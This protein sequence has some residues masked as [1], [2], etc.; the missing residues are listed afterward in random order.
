MINISLSK[1]LGVH[2]LL[3]DAKD[4]AKK[5]TLM[6]IIQNFIL[7]LTQTYIVLYVIDKVGFAEAAILSSILLL[8]QGILDYPLGVLS[9]SIGQKWVLSL[10]HI[11][12]SSGFIFLV[13]ANSFIEFVPIY[14]LFGLAFAL[15]S[16]AFE[17]Y[18]DNNY[19]VTV[20]DLDPDRKIYGFF[21]SRVQALTQLTSLIAFILG[22]ILSTSIGRQNSFLIQA[23]LGLL[24]SVII[25]LVLNDYFNPEDQ[26]LAK[27][28][29]KRSIANY[30]SISKA[31]IKFIFS[32]KRVFFFITG[33]ILFQSIWMIWAL[34]ILFVIYFGYTGTDLLAGVFRTT[35]F[36]LGVPTLIIV[37]NISKK[38]SDKKWIYIFHFFHSILFFGGFA[39][40]LFI[41]PLNN[42]LNLIGIILVVINF[43]L[44]GIFFDLTLVLR[45]RIMLDLIPENIRNSVYSLI[46][47]IVG[48][49]SVPFMTLVGNLI[50]TYT[51]STGILFLTLFE[52][53]AA[54]AFY[55]SFKFPEPTS[56]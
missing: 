8:F 28:I 48:L 27:N 25:Y 38:L 52:I 36:L 49:C 20:K 33:L 47:T 16:G 55:L 24:F 54:I 3:P 40:I 19:R 29:Q 45:Q 26:D 53:A 17:T 21:I 32:S 5:Y 14:A 13:F 34:L 6:I 10:S 39:L 35:V 15:F 9:D 37:G 4:L 11:C 31:G 51:I 42:T 43:S 50:V 44:T 56:N 1:F 12:F 41:I 23:I 7:L 46:P 22:G 18:L 2:E 30:V